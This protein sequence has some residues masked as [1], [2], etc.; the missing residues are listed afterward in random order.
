MKLTGASPADIGTTLALNARYPQELATLQAIDPAT[1]TALAANPADAQAGAAAVGQVARA[2]GIPPDQAIV[3]LTA[4]QQVPRDQLAIAATVGPQLA[5]ARSQL[6]A[7]ASV[8]TDDLA[9]LSAHG[10]EVQQAA[11][12][13]PVQWKRWWWVCLVAQ[14]AFLPGV[15]VMSGRW[16][17]KRAAADAAEHD[18]LVQRELAELS[19]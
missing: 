1:L 13:S 10:S 6:Q 2:F 3:R 19:Q 5:Q 4:T 16:N 15:F 7:V 8:P 11:A 9:Y 14:I 12:D 17:P 18:Q